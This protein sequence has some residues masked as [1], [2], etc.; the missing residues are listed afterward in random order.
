MYV[1]IYFYSAEVDSS[2][3]GHMILYT[4][5]NYHFTRIDN[6]SVK[7]NM[8]MYLGI[9]CIESKFNFESMIMIGEI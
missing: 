7:K 6:L 2:K 3:W 8:F 4:T 9:L 1:C 5:P